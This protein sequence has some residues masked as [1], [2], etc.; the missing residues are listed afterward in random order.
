MNKFEF[1]Q[2]PRF[3]VMILGTVA[4]YLEAKGWIGEAERNLIAGLSALFVGIRTADRFGEKIGN[5]F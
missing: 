4:V 5:K 2:S 3:W 1:L